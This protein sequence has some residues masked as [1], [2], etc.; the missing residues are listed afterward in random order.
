MWRDLWLSCY[1]QGEIAGR[2]NIHKDTVNAI[3][4]KMANLPE[5][6]KPA[7][8]HLTDFEVPIHNV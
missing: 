1:T 4:R 5:S 3:C 6:D 7:A 2:E 8:S